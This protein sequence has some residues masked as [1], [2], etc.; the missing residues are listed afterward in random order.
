[1]ELTLEHSMDLEWD[2]WII[3]REAVREIGHCKEESEQ[4]D[5]FELDNARK[6]IRPGQLSIVR[7]PKVEIG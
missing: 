3:Q 1:M 7:A 6:Y 5:V 2:Q 4:W